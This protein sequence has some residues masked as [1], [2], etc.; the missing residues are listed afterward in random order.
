VTAASV[1]AAP[2]IRSI[3]NAGSYAPASMPNSAIAQGSIFVIFGAE[4]GPVALQPAAG[5]PL[6]TRLAGTSVRVA[7]ASTTLD[8]PLLYVWDK[9][10]A[11]ILP[12]AAP[13]GIGLVSVVSSGRTSQAGAIRIVRSSPGILTQN[14]AGSGAA[15]AQNF[16]SDVD[17]PRNTLA[18]PARPGQTVVLWG[19]GL[20][21]ISGSDA[22]PPVSRNLDTP[23]EVLVGGRPAVVRYKGRSS[24]C[25]GADQ[26][27]FEVPR[28]VD[29]CYVPVVVRAGEVISNFTTISIAAP[30]RECTDTSGLTGPEIDRLQGSGSVR[31]GSIGLTVAR[32]TEFSGETPGYYE[33]ASADFALI[34]GSILRNRIAIGQPSA[35]ACIVYSP[36]EFIPATFP[37][38]TP[39]EAGPS[40]MVS[41][42]KG[43]KQLPR[44]S[45]GNYGALFSSATA[46][47]QY[48][49]PG[50]YA[51]DNGTGGADVGPF[52]IMLTL[53]QPFSTTVQQSVSGTSVTWRGGDPAGLVTITGFGRPSFQ[54]SAASFICTERAVAGHFTVPAYV[55]QSFPAD[56]VLTVTAN[57]ATYLSERR[58]RAPG[59]DIAYVIFDWPEY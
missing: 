11:A 28:D 9:Q 54:S 35:G 22:A 26:I 57:A 51:I 45:E 7:V 47:P 5:F 34:D 31:F 41:G 49:E 56:T 3:L 58:F 21:P 4:L 43:T 39:L 12:S 17:Q 30:G 46:Q 13:L 33:S 19:T 38:S 29:G 48:F 44:H 16:V 53:P 2:E 25:A 1:D 52:R 40:I 14:Q 24:C 36:T 32:L 15:L 42:P 59:L 20:G 37:E 23:L 50:V 8:A 10:V 18:H 27:N 6:P 55:L